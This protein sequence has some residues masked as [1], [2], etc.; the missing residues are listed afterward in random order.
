VN[1][2]QQDGFTP[3]HGA[4]QNGQLEMV[5]LL[6]EH[7]ADPSMRD[8]AGR[9]PLDFAREGGYTEVSEILGNNRT[10]GN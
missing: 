7:G 9:S 5:Q 8:T 2:V 10:T 4:A 6:L 3:L 1:A